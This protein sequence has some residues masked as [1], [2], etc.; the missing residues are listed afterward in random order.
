M[1][2]FDADEPVAPPAMRRKRFWTADRIIGWSGAAIA[3]MAAFFP[4]YVFINEDKF[5]LD[6]IRAMV[7]GNPAVPS[8]RATQDNNDV[9]SLKRQTATL[10]PRED[11]LVT[12]SVS[13]AKPTTPEGE[14]ELPAQPF[15]AAPRNFRLLKVIKGQAMI[16]DATGIY[17]VRKGD[18]LPDRTKVAGLEQRDGKWVLVSDSGATYSAGDE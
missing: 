18:V 11:D 16:E 4:W 7:S 10:R 12:G 13:A 15:P 8:R 1:N 17:V 5:G 9:G 3:L 6:A 2:D 14:Q